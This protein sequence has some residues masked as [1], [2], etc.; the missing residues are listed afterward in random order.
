M[1]KKKIAIVWEGYEA[2][3]IDSYLYYLLEAWPVDDEFTIFYNQENLGVDRLKLLLKN[4]KIIFQPVKT[5]FRF[6]EGKT[7]F[8]LFFKY[9]LHIF[10]P[11][12][13]LTNIYHYKRKLMNKNFDILIAQN[14]GY[15]GSYGVLSSCFGAKLA[16]I[17]TIALVIHHAA[18]SSLPGH[19]TFRYFIEK[20]LKNILHSIIPISNPTKETIEKHTNLSKDFDQ[21]INVIENGVPLPKK[22]KQYILNQKRKL[23]V[24]ILGRLDRHKGHDDFLIALTLL[25]RDL[26]RKISVEFIGSYK[27]DDFKRISSLITDLDLHETVEIKGF[28]NASTEKI[29]LDLDLLIM[30]TKDFEGFGLT[31]IEALHAR[32]PVIST[33]VGVALELFSEED[34]MAVMPSDHI[35]ISK[36]LETFINSE[37]K[38]SLISED[39]LGKLKKYDSKHSSRRYREHLTREFKLQ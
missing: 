14:G 6:Y 18:N 9:L 15:P 11:I 3:G 16:K 5:F 20:N 35:G 8:S 31:I 37:N 19:K 23:K 32:V 1:I 38:Q 28:V 34:I 22:K 29:I 21:N 33:R 25:P 17:Q 24:A 7:F 36:A 13:F 30:A 27:D 12:L 39:V 4:E 2:G 10:S 26:L